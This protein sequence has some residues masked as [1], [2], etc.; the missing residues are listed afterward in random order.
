MPIT[1]PPSI[2]TRRD[3]LKHLATVGAGL[4]VSS[5]VVLAAES[6]G[7]TEK[8]RWLLCSDTHVAE[9]RAL[10]SKGG[11]MA[12]RLEQTVK[13]MLAGAGGKPFGLLHGGDCAFDNGQPGDYATLTALME[14]LREAGIPLHFALGNHD[15]RE[16]FLAG[17][18]ALDAELMNEKKTWH[19]SMWRWW[20]GRMRAG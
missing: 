12:A 18:A 17:C 7:K 19:R 14:P 13:E 1:L 11:N 16:N 2:V 3:T 9:D 4:F 15:H 10:E 5:R 8:S 6:D 20:R